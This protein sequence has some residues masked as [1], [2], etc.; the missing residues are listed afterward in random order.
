MSV[1]ALSRAST[2]W[3]RDN[4]KSASGGKAHEEF[5]PPPTKG[6]DR[7]V[8]DGYGPFESKHGLAVSYIKLEN[9]F[10][11]PRSWGCRPA[12]KTRL[13]PYEVR[14]YLTIFKYSAKE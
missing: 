13:Q 5:S 10:L 3:D 4:Y 2:V 9:H 7:T 6:C 11:L 1:A 8:I 14:W 12:V